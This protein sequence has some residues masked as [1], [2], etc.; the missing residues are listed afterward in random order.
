LICEE[1]TAEARSP[2]G[3]EGAVVSGSGSVVTETVVL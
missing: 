2:V 1:E 3:A